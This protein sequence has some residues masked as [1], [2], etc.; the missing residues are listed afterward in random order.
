MRNGIVMSDAGFEAVLGTVLVMGWVFGQIDGQDFA[1]PVSGGLA[2]AFGLGLIA[3]AVGL[4]EVV[5][6]EAVSDRFLSLLAAGNA[7]FAVLLAVWRLAADGFTEA[8]SAV[9]LG[10]RR[11]PPGARPGSGRARRPP[12][13]EVLGRRRLITPAEPL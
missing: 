9:V 5:K 11:R 6:R 13:K 4:A 10:D 12:I 7:G 3:L 2:A 1:D 8:G